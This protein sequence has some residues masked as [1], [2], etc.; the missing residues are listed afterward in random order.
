[1]MTA[2]G[3]LTQNRNKFFDVHGNSSNVE[4]F[5]RRPA[6]PLKNERMHSTQKQ[7]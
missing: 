1:M 5:I 2:K 7:I 3:T 4:S 6:I